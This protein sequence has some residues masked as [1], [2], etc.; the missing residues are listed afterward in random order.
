MLLDDQ[1]K[2]TRESNAPLIA[3][4][5]HVAQASTCLSARNLDGQV[6]A[7]VLVTPIACCIFML[8]SVNYVS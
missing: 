4:Y 1:L 3:E 7:F 8:T 6:M 2:R 5:A